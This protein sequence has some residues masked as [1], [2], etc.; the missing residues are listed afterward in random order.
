MVCSLSLG[1]LPRSRR[2]R[3]AATTAAAATLA[4]AMPPALSRADVLGGGADVPGGGADVPGGGADVLGGGAD[5]LGGG[6]LAGGTPKVTPRTPSKPPSTR[7]RSTSAD[8]ATDAIDDGGGTGVTSTGSDVSATA[9]APIATSSTAPE[10]LA[11]IER[12]S[13]SAVSASVI[14]TDHSASIAATVAA[15]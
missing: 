3:R 7:S 8:W 1:L 4:A 5:V 14:A 2:K 11:P 13:R 9:P 12:V 15:V 6:G 10:T